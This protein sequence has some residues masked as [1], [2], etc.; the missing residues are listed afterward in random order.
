MRSSQASLAATLGVA[1]LLGCGGSKNGSKLT[2]LDA[3]QT[4]VDVGVFPSTYDSSEAGGEA[5]TDSPQDQVAAGTDTAS[6]D[7]AQDAVPD[8]HDVGQEDATTSDGDGAI[9]DPR[10][11]VI[12]YVNDGTGADIDIQLSQDSISANW[13]IDEPENGIAG[14]EWAIGTSPDSESIRPFT[15]VGTQSQASASGLTL[16]PDGTVIY[17]TVRA[18]NRTGLRR[19]ASS[20]GVQVGCSVEGTPLCPETRRRGSGVNSRSFAARIEDDRP[21]KDILGGHAALRE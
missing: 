6:A 16:P 11:F 8:S 9:V 1:M 4:N 17:V 19:T 10:P 3:S 18:T 5:A 12:N 7:A 14:Y 15:S 20:D 2:A 21:R 13:S